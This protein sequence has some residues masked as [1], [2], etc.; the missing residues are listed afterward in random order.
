VRCTRRDIEVWISGGVLQVEG[1]GGVCLKR[2][3][4]ALQA[5]PQKRCGALE[6]KRIVVVVM[7]ISR[8]R[9]SRLAVRVKC[10]PHSQHLV[11][12]LN[13]VRVTPYFIVGQTRSK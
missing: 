10:P 5:L 13:L 12:P 7:E 2:S 1:R 11:N 3:G 6:L 4:D 8:F 9:S